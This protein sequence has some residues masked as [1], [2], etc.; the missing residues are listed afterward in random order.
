MENQNLKKMNNKITDHFT[1]SE[2]EHSNTAEKFKINNTIPRNLLDNV[3]FGCE[4]ILEPLRI[5]IGKPIKITS[6][7]R[8]VKLNN[9]IGGVPNSYHTIGCAA[10][11]HVEDFTDATE[12]FQILRGNKYVDVLLFEHTKNGSKWIHVQWSPTREP[13][14][15]FN[16]NYNAS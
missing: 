2:F 3:K 13:R 7:F 14:Q 8:S 1:L 16:F 4:K 15:H 9:L 6:G 5:T 10:D 12:K 11:I